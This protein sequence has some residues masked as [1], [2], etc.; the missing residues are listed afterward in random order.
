M[1]AGHVAEGQHPVSAGIAAGAA[2]PVGD[3]RKIV[4]PG[5]ELAAMIGLD[6]TPRARL[7]TDASY[8]RF[9]GANGG[10]DLR[11]I[12]IGADVLLDLAHPAG[13]RL[14][15]NGGG[16][17][18]RSEFGRNDLPP[19]NDLA[20]RAGVGL[21]AALGN[22]RLFSEIGFHNIFSGSNLSDDSRRFI[23]I[24]AGMMFR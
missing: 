8:R 15:A 12:G 3:L 5:H 13:A 2:A 19:E 21:A 7:R 4:G 1:V 23:A 20:A 16:G 10:A 17:V 22:T 11:V 18:S 9:A 24:R 14:Y 6:A